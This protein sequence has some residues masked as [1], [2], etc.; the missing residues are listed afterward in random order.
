MPSK[1]IYQETNWLI[2]V[3][4]LFNH[5][6]P[7]MHSEMSHIPALSFDVY[8]FAVGFVTNETVFGK[9]YST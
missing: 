5:N 7:I 4:L 1:Q 8:V 9:R 6:Q 3:A 2:F